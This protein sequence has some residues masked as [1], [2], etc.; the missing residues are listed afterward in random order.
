M[1]KKTKKIMFSTQ[2]LCLASQVASWEHS[3]S[4]SYL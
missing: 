2:Y 1:E 4:L 3:L